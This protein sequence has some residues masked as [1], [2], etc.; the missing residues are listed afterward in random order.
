MPTRKVAS[1]AEIAGASGTVDH[2]RMLLKVT[3]RGP[4]TVRLSRMAS[5]AAE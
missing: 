4:S 5:S 2:L 3:T 1:K